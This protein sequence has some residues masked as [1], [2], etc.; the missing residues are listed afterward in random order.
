MP[1]NLRVKNS[2]A[3]IALMG[4]L[5]S[6]TTQASQ[7]EIS[8]GIIKIGILNDQSGPYSDLSGQGSVEAARL[9]IEEF[10][11]TVAGAKVE[12]VVGDHQNKADV[13]ATKARE[14]FDREGV[15]AIA[16][17]S[18][19]SVGL[20]VQGL[21]ADRKKITLVA[22]ASNAFTGASCS[23]YSTQWIYNSYSN[24]H[25][26]ANMLVKRGFDSWYLMTVDYAFGHAF[27][28]DIR[29]TVMAAG[30]EVLGEV[31]FPLN[32]P[33]LSSYLIQAQGSRAEVVVAASAGSDMANTVKQAA[34]FGITPNQ[35][36]AAPAVFITDV[37]SMGLA[38]AQ[39]LQFLTAFYW[40]R[41][42]ASR[43]WANKFYE[44]R[45]AMPTMT[46]AGVYSA[47]RHYLEAISASNSDD[48]D[49]VAKK[50][51]ELPVNDMFIQG[52]SIRE[53][54]Q[55]MHDMYLVEVKK[56]SDSEKP[57]D[58]YNVIDSVSASEAFQPLADS[59]CPLVNK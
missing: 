16:D 48:A 36:L 3:L 49:V 6:L 59:L 43:E 58:Y 46:Q 57:W 24:G 5:L 52:G 21:A 23:P 35:T 17:F 11:G 10:G 9:A 27:S 26:L 38:Q 54:G 45:G 29:K 7:A 22:A 34:E 1:R 37:H 25:G 2:T 56:P 18:N 12:L 4:G 32:S 30:K 44:R 20:A 40:D 14:W 50:M 39:G 28:D 31:R 47:V 41:T 19:S 13:G 33:D 53:D 42:D 15:D 55:V 8:D 51:R